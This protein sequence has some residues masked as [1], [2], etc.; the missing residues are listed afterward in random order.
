VGGK[1]KGGRVSPPNLKPNFA[2]VY[3][4]VLRSVF[5]IFC[6]ETRSRW[7]AGR[8]PVRAYARTDKRTTRKYN[9]AAAHG[10]RRMKIAKANL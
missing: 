7:Q 2:H 1:G 8:E 3:D 6:I 4:D 10:D 9:V 5:F